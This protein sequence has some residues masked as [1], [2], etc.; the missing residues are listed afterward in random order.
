MSEVGFGAN[1]HTQE[2]FTATKPWRRPDTHR[3]EGPV[4]NKNNCFM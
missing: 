1:D 4:E 2:K 3:V